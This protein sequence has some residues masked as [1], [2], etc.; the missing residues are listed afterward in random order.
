MDKPMTI[1]EYKAKKKE[2]EAK[3]FEILRQFETTTGATVY[4]VDINRVMTA[5]GSQLLTSIDIESRL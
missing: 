2:A 4:S 3:I 1:L 5:A